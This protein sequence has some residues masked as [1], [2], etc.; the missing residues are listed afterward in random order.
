MWK[1]F[2]ELKYF[3]TAKYIFLGIILSV[4]TYQFVTKSLL[5]NTIYFNFLIETDLLKNLVG[6]IAGGFVGGVIFFITTNR[7][8]N[9]QKEQE[10]YFFI[11]NKSQNYFIMNMIAFSIGGFSYKLIWNI[12]DLTNYNNLLQVLFSN[13]H[14][15]DYV[16][17]IIS[18]WVF[19]IFLSLG[20]KKRLELLFKGN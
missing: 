4:I 5:N 16:G 17:I 3:L 2:I 10:F 15:I 13:D 18:F 20:I 8:R 6:I 11:K 12:F 9:I 1:K 14:M 7:I 19:S